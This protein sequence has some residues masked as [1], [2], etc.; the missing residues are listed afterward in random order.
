MVAWPLSVPGSA[1]FAGDFDGNGVVLSADV[2]AI[3]VIANGAKADQ[4][5]SDVDGNGFKLQADVLL[6]NANQPS[7]TP[8]KPT[9][10]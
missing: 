4:D 5:R 7:A 1:I 2:L 3:N 6:A 9:G 10:H 8:A